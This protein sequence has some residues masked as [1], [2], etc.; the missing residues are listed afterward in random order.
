MDQ[1]I[2]ELS[3]E[4]PRY[5]YEAYEFVQEAVPF[6]QELLDRLPT[7]D[8]DP[9]ADYHV[10]GDELVRGACEL[11]V[12]EFGMMAPVVFR[13]W[14]LT[15]TDDFGHIVFALIGIEKLAKSD[16]DDP[17]DFH[18]LFDLEKVLT[19]GFALTTRTPHAGGA[20]R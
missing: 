8:D 17:D 9:D 6:T 5:A 2:F 3:R 1:K 18:D 11:A 4:D 7:E 15:T 19:E 20:D 16:R 14:G 10:S 13:R 12:R